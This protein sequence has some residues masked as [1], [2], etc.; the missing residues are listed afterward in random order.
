MSK[1]IKSEDLGSLILSE[2]SDG[3]RLFDKERKMNISMR[4]KTERHALIDAITYYQ[5]TYAEVQKENSRLHAA[6]NDFVKTLSSDNF[7]LFGCD[8]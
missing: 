3:F 7:S 6:I 5:K 4:A 1:L 2:Y 8:E